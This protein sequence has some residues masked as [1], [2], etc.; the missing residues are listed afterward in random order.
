[1]KN[2]IVKSILI[3]SFLFLVAVT[4]GQPAPGETG[5]GGGEGS[6]PVGGGAPIGGGLM[7]MFSLVLG[8]LARRIYEM[9]KNILE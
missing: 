6:G 3:V 7:I 2:Q 9:R 1:M 5:L 8:Y 4:F